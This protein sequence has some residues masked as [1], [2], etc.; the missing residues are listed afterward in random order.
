MRAGLFQFDRLRDWFAPSDPLEARLRIELLRSLARR[1]IPIVW[2][3]PVSAGLVT[4]INLDW[5]AGT[6]AFLW[7]G[8]VLL[9]TS[10]VATMTRKVLTGHFEPHDAGLL[11]WQVLGYML[12]FTL[13]WPAM[14]LLVWIDGNALNNA[15]LTAFIFT[16]IVISI[17][18]CAP[19]LQ[20]ALL[21]VAV[22]VPLLA[23]HALTGAEFTRWIGAPVQVLLALFLGYLACTFHAA[24]R[25][26]ELQKI[27][28]ETLAA[29]LVAARDDA[30]QANRAK[31]AFLASMSH[32]LRTPLNAVIGFSDLI[33]ERVLGD[34]NPA[35]YGEY[36]DDIHSSGRHLL[37]L[38]D[39]I[40]DLAKI[41]A[42]KRRFLPVDLNLEGAV[43]D[44][45]SLVRT[46]A[47]KAGVALRTDIEPRS[48]LRADERAT[49]Q[50]LA[51]LL[52]NAV[53]FTSAG[54]TA[55][56]FARTNARG[57]LELG[58]ADNGIG[59]SAEEL[60]IALEP[61]GQASGRFTVEGH[62]TGLGLPIV[63]AL[64]E[65]QGATF[66]IESAAGKGTRAWGEFPA[67]PRV[68]QVA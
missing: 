25:E 7:Y 3:A 62:G 2:T 28:N 38:I 61:F 1:C 34:I 23:T 4:I 14:V 12:P 58:V 37:G 11:T 51:N 8:C 43:R 49:I 20:M 68:R 33:R 10:L 53:K 66:H 31:S 67:S 63:R 13:M 36:I 64:L 17:A 60:A 35:K 15:Y 46:Q 47:A 39:D 41:E 56:V 44:A 54:G 52:S 50:I 29:D 32:E 18:V 48:A 45:L 26:V 9:A 22:Y 19:C 21:C 55:T 40:L 24:L 59:M 6:A 30:L 42:G 5:I 16:N 27:R 57:G 65:A